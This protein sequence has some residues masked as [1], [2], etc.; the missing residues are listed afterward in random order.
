VDGK[1]FS[2]RAEEVDDGEDLL[3]AVTAKNA[4]P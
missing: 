2:L 1:K 4:A 3:L